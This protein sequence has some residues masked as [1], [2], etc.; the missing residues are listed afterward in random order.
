MIFFLIFFLFFSFLFF[1]FL[2][3]YIFFEISLIP[4]L[5]LILGWG[6]QPERII[7]GLYLLFY[8]LL[9][10]LPLLIGILI[11]IFKIK[12]LLI[13]NLNLIY[14]N[15]LILYYRLIIAFLVKIPIFFVHL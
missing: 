14:I 9:V 4:I 15:N 2:F 1:S 12:N 8:T 11:F 13:D 6:Y 3:F 7:A 5:Y 10:S